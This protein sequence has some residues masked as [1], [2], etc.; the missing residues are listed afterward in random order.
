MDRVPIGIVVASDRAAMGVYEDRGG[1]AI[2]AYLE[3]VL[4]THW[5]PLKV[6]ARDERDQIADL[7]I[8]LADVDGCPLILTTGG[9]WPAPAT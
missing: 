8:G 2:L 7:L 4:T 1:P 9:T 5:Q 3:R 6:V